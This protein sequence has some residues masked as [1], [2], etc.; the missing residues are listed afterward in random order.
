M[1]NILQQIT[2]NDT[3][4]PYLV[5]LIAKANELKEEIGSK[6]KQTETDESALKFQVIGLAETVEKIMLKNNCGEYVSQ[7]FTYIS[8]YFKENYNISEK[9]E[10]LLL[11]F[12]SDY[13]QYERTIVKNNCP[14]ILSGKEVLRAFD[15]NE[16]MMSDGRLPTENKLYKSNVEHALITLDKIDFSRLT[17]DQCLFVSEKMSNIIKNKQHELEHNYRLV[18]KKGEKK[19]VKKK[20]DPYEPDPPQE[21][22]HPDNKITQALIKIRNQFDSMITQTQYMKFP[23]PELE[24]ELAGY[25]ETFYRTLRFIT[26]RKHKASIADWSNMSLATNYFNANYA[27][28]SI[29][30]KAP[31]CVKC[32]EP[33][34]INDPTGDK[35][36]F[37]HIQMYNEYQM[38]RYDRDG[39]VV[40]NPYI[41][42][43]KRCHGTK[44]K[45]EIMSVE[46]I[47]ESLVYINTLLIDLVNKSDIYK[48]ICI[49]FEEL[50]KPGRLVTAHN[51]SNKLLS[52]K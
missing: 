40:A 1:S 2:K 29:K 36:I 21:T 50:T 35:K 17:K 45:E 18:N 12:F 52:M 16:T 23:S 10:H 51:T 20:Y 49:Y 3:K 4:D 19:D 34:E 32:K 27:S 33:D 22:S 26:D 39:M 41:W 28:S 25:F 24:N 9:T 8:N 30:F 13:P 14:Y 11:S 6:L 48:A 15:I 7:I 47:S 42:R 44:Q 37:R 43:C 5:K 38:D 31:L 46:R